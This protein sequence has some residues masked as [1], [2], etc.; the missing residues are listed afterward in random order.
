MAK[1][2]DINQTSASTH[3]D[4][5]KNEA[6]SG[7]REASCLILLRG[8][9]QYAPGASSRGPDEMP[10]SIERERGVQKIGNHEAADQQPV[11]EETV[12]S[13]EAEVRHQ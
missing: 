12:M 8:D 9:V 4:G 10:P 13:S 3:L 1:A 11:G 7:I 2:E 5:G 6:P